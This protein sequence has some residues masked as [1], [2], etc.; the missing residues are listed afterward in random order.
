MLSI[1][2]TITRTA[3]MDTQ[4][5]SVRTGSQPPAEEKPIYL[6]MDDGLRIP[7]QEISVGGKFSVYAVNPSS[8]II[9]CIVDDTPRPAPTLQVPSVSSYLAP[10]ALV[11]ARKTP[12][13]PQEPFLRWTPLTSAADSSDMPSMLQKFHTVRAAEHS[14]TTDATLPEYRSENAHSSASV[15][16]SGANP[17]AQVSSPSSFQLSN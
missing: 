5:H 15:S 9:L 1:Y 13:P 6:Q 10:D 2:T 4:A 3:G 12:E 8:K 7:L 14:S 16:A 11:R 17:V